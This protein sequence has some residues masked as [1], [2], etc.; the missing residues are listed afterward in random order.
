MRTTGKG[1][2]HV[3]AIADTTLM[4]RVSSG[5]ESAFAEL[6]HRYNRKVLDFFYAM[7]RN[8]QVAE[9]L[10]GDTFARIWHVRRRYAATGS[11]PAYLFSFARHIW[12]EHC[13]R[14]RKD[15]KLGTVADW[16]DVETSLVALD[17]FRP[18]EAAAS[19]ELEAHIVRALDDL[20][21]EQRMVFVMRVMQ[22]MSLE[23]I[24]EVMQCPVNTVRSRK[25]LALK[26]LREALRDLLAV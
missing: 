10:A 7:S 11:F 22:R 15:R 23:D 19:E 17:A 25:L 21:E 26:R 3:H 24:A 5:D 12:L 4:R 1:S 20:P 9:E 13:R 8:A 18:D 2:A 16:A 14:M 6:Y